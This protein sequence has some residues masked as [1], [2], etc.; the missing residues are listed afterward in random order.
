MVL[1][2]WYWQVLN[3]DFLTARAEGQRLIKKEIENSRGNI[4]FA[5]GS[6]L[7][8]TQP[9]FLLF[10]QPKVLKDPDAISR[11]LADILFEFEKKK[12]VKK[13]EDETK[14]K[15]R[16]FQI[17]EN[18]YDKLKKDLFWVSLGWRVDLETKNKISG[19][20]MYGVGFDTLSSRFYPESSAASHI[21]GFVGLDA[22][23][24]SK[25]YFGL[26]GYYD[27]ELQGRRGSVVEEKDAAGLP[28]LIGRFLSRAPKD[29][30]TLKLNI[31]RTVQYI[32]EEKLKKGIEKYGAKGVSAVVMEPKTGNILAM[33]SYPNYDPSNVGEYPGEYFRN[34]LIAD[35]YEPGSTFKVLVMA[36][37]V[38]EKVV[39][40]DTVCDKCAGPRQIGGYAIRTWNNKYKEGIT[41]AETIVH[42]DNTGMVFV[43][44]K[45][46]FEKFYE[47]LGKFG[48]GKLTGIDL[49]DERAPDVRAKDGWKEIDLATAS[50]GQ[51]V[52]VTGLQIVTAVGAIANGGKMMEPHVASEVID[53]SKKDRIL[54]REI[55]KPISEE[56]AKAVKDMMV[57]A[58]EEGEA[59]YLKPKGFKVAGKTG[60]AQIPIAGH[61]DPNKTIASFVGFAPADDPKF[62]MLVRYQE[63]SSSIYG[64]ETAAPT[65]FD[66][67]KE[68]FTYYG[69]APSE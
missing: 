2:L 41:M 12:S 11:K 13:Y 66:I 54:P 36:A 46:G 8:S 47:Y 28:I 60:T 61:Y 40:P 15:E 3:Y 5:D 26:E 34:P 58:V 9:Y 42:S 68:L 21:A 45:L 55:G 65:F 51:G 64:A 31:D 10:A 43:A 7:A 32:V 30:K 22:Y 23:G 29:G 37:G 56:A 69:I 24:E 25:G 48:F 44:E 6:V 50:F 49:Q 17:R 27:G 39:K 19:L 20:K 16:L 4:L 67:A 14:E 35:G 53:G 59:K 38:N 57:R 1:R 33:A 62:I 63:P 52:S 18:I